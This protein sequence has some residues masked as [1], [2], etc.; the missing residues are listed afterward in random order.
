MLRATNYL[1][2]AKQGNLMAPVDVKMPRDLNI[3]KWTIT[4]LIS[5]RSR[6]NLINQYGLNDLNRAFVYSYSVREYVLD[7]LKQAAVDSELIEN[8]QKVTNFPT[9]SNSFN[10]AL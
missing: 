7:H 8:A 3:V 1:N 6:I 2:K 9:F 5:L 10:R 4:V